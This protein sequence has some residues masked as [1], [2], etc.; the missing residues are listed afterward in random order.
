MKRLELRLQCHCGDPWDFL[1]FELEPEVNDPESAR[2]PAEFYIRGHFYHGT[3]WKRVKNA[4]KYVIRAEYRAQ[5]DTLFL[6]KTPIE[7][8]HE[9]TG[10]CLKEFETVEKS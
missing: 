3:F 4:I 8:L 7:K 1:L 2:W 10:K 5:I 6:G 9:F